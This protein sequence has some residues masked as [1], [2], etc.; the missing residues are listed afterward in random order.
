MKGCNMSSE[1]KA[2]PGA[3]PLD[4]LRSNGNQQSLNSIPFERVRS[5]LTKNRFERL[6]MFAVH[7]VIDIKNCSHIQGTVIDSQVIA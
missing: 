2:H 1:L 6:S 5:R 4:E 7:E 3:S